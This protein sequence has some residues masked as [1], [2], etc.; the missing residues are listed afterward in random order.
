MDIKNII[1]M[2]KTILLNFIKNSATYTYIIGISILS[3]YLT[4][5]SIA[6]HLTYYMNRDMTRI[7]YKGYSI[8][9]VI[10]LISLFVSLFFLLIAILVKFV[11]MIS[12]KYDSMEF[13]ILYKNFYHF[14]ESH[15]NN[16][17]PYALWIMLGYSSLIILILSFILIEN[18]RSLINQFYDQIP[19]IQNDDDIYDNNSGS[20][21]ESIIEDEEGAAFV[22]KMNDLISRMNYI[23]LPLFIIIAGTVYN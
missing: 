15:Y 11:Q 7:E 17:K 5:I 19:N 2:I 12:D 22:Y 1:I 8:L 13:L 21:I 6:S 23:F 18:G 14:L 20:A 9:Y 10:L 3:I 16:E 4:K